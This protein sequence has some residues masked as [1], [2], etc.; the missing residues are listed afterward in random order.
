MNDNMRDLEVMRRLVFLMISVWSVLGVQTMAGATV[1]PKDL[2]SNEL[3]FL[4]KTASDVYSTECQY[5]V[6][7]CMSVNFCSIQWFFNGIPYDSWSLGN[8]SDTKFKLEDSNQTLK[9]LSADVDSEGTYTCVVS[10][11]VRNINRSI[12]L[13][14][15]EKIWLN[16]PIPLESSSGVC[17]D[18]MAVLGGNASFFCQF[19]YRNPGA[20][21]QKSWRKLNQTYGGFQLVDFYYIPGTEFTHGYRKEDENVIL[22]Q[23]N[24]P[25]KP[26]KILS[27]WLNIT[28]VTE[29]ALG[30]YQVHCKISGFLTKVNLTLSLATTEE[31]VVK[32]T[33]T[34]I[35]VVVVT[36]MI[37]LL[38]LVV[39]SWKRY[40][41]DVKLWYHDHRA[42]L[43]TE[44]II[45][46]EKIV[47]IAS[48]SKDI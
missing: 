44:G 28:N 24:C 7:Q 43:E 5:R 17:K 47:T 31:H 6:L 13:R 32:V 20:F 45:S 27:T 40:G 42:A 10:N 11:G 23:K 35:V 34:T 30:R 12:N 8:N 1:C 41:T 21:L 25:E 15:Q 26:F 39:L 33:H 2:D 46:R 29:E 4:D 22:T 14:I 48:P 36:T 38:S 16:K 9:F 19:K 18:Q 3:S 37:I